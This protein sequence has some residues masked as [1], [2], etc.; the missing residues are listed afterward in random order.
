MLCIQ[1]FTLEL[2]LKTGKY[3]HDGIHAVIGL[4]CKIQ[5]VAASE[6]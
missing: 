2:K 5:K 4:T 1:P 6:N 3:K